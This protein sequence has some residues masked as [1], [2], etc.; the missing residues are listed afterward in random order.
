MSEVIGQDRLISIIASEAKNRHSSSYLINAP[1]GMGKH[2]IASSF[3][4]ALMCEE[5]GERG[6]CGIC[7]CCK[8]FEANTTPDVVYVE[9]DSDGK[10]VKVDDIRN[11]VVAD[12]YIRPQFS[13]TKVYIIDLDYV[14]E[15]GQNVLLKSIE[16][17]PQSAVFIMITSSPD[18]VLGTVMSRAMELK[19]E[20]YTS[21]AIYEILKASGAGGSRE[22][23][24]DCISYCA[25]NPGRA[26]SIAS[27]DTFAKLTEDVR[28]LIL[29]VGDRS[30]SDILTDDVAFLASCKDRIDLVFE[31]MLKTLDVMAMY[32]KAPDNKTALK[33][34][35]D[36]KEFVLSN[37][38]LSTVKIGRCVEAI[39]NMRRA[40]AVNCNL[41]NNS[42]VLL[43]TM[44]EELRR[45]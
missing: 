40:L 45:I 6:A 28:R 8:Y 22:E 1:K 21:D 12:A 2:L 20:P 9:G 32:L 36:I 42:G 35:P 26:I 41:E 29:S 16:E 4:K 25:S 15:D 34:G 27:D 30:I 7:R 17:P 33:A 43:L 3:A 13:K 37:K 14:A 19:L 24:S 31:I 38:R 23:L 5:P 18:K 39:N 44:H 10:N 11:N